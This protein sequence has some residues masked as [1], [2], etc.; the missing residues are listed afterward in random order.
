MKSEVRILIKEKH[1]SRKTRE[2]CYIRREEIEKVTWGY[3]LE[4]WRI[5][6]SDLGNLF[7]FCLSSI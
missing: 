4:E 3:F 7:R 5:H 2:N 1:D 6:Q